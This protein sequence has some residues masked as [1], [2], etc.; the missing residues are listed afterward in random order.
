MLS[1]AEPRLRP[2]Y[3][4]IHGLSMQRVCTPL[5]RISLCAA[6]KLIMVSYHRACNARSK[7]GD[8]VPTGPEFLGE[9]SWRRPGPRSWSQKTNHQG[10]CRTEMEPT[11]STSESEVRGLVKPKQVKRTAGLRQSREAADSLSQYLGDMQAYDVLD[12]EQEVLLAKDI[13]RLEIA[14]FRALLSH[15]PALET[16]IAALKSRMDVPREVLALRKL[17]KTVP[18]ARSKADRERDLDAAAQ[19]LRQCDADRLALA[20]ADAAVRK[21]FA[22]KPS[23]KRYLECVAKARVAQQQAKNRFMTANLRFV[24]SVARR[25][26]RGLMPLA[27]LIQEGNLGLMRAV[28]RFDHTRGYRFSTYASWWIRHHLNRALSDKARLVRIPVHLLDDAQRVARAS[29]EL[30]ALTS[31]APTS[32]ELVERT[33]LG[34]E[35]LAFVQKHAAVRHHASLDRK[36]T[37]EGDTTLL[38]LIP[39]PSEVE[40]EEA[41]DAA[42]WSGELSALLDKLTP[43]EA[44]ILRFRFGLDDGEELTLREIGL[45]YNLSRERIR[46]LQEQALEKLRGELARMARRTPAAAHVAA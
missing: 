45:K 42:Q 5:R 36:L 17:A 13:E 15:P 40:P 9:A 11:T 8:E 1:L 44:A 20:D 16:I 7:D 30:R 31:E 29:A 12:P 33:G 46:Q 4:T 21:A 26:D 6:T 35:K 25:Y 32:A 18:S 23:E 14:H 22:D 27:D 24:V 41:I 19:R 37:Q 39:C 3:A 28:E 43:I 34:E 2:W 10:S 38:D